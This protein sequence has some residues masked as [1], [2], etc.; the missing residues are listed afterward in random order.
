MKK[1]LLIIFLFAGLCIS[2]AAQD[3]IRTKDGRTI[4]AKILEVGDSSISYKRYSNPNGPT[5]TLALSQIKSIEYQSGD[6]NVFGRSN[7]TVRANTYENKKYKELKHIYNPRR[8]NSM[9]GDPHSVFGAGLA[10]FFIPGLGQVID[11]EVGR[12]LAIWAGSAALTVGFYASL[13]NWSVKY[14]S[15]LESQGY[16]P[17][18]QYIDTSSLDYSTSPSLGGCLL[19]VA[20]GVVYQIW[21]ISDACK[22]A[23]VKNMYWQDCM[24]Y[25]SVSLSM[26]PYFAFTPTPGSGLQPVTGLSLKLTF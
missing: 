13:L 1:L 23:K 17:D 21:N 9:P 12:G 24:G 5:F 22:V 26:D 15:W 3:I 6:S 2:A 19:W 7:N 16:S 10:S 20:A 18:D 8:Y 14:T 4:E 25:S 11:G